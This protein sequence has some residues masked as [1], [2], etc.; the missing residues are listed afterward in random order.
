M[1]SVQEDCWSDSRKHPYRVR[2]LGWVH[3]VRWVYAEAV[4]LIR[5]FN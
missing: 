4:L 3:S 2:V 1:E 5:G